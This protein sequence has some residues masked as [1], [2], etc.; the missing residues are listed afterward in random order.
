MFRS[1]HH[2]YVFLSCYTHVKY[3][4]DYAFENV[5]TIHIQI[6]FP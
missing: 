4:R 6:L 3:I 2:F 5:K 1:V